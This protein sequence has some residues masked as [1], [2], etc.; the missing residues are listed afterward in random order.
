MNAPPLSRKRK[1]DVER[2]AEI[3]RERRARTRARILAVTFDIFGRENGLYCR[4]EEVCAAAGITRQTF[5]NHFTGMEDLREALTWEVS[6][7]FLVAVTASIDAMP[8]AARRTAAAVRYYLE[9]GRVDPRWAW[10]IVNLSANGVV[11][12]AE[13]FA[14]AR[15]TIAEGIEA[16]LFTVSDDRIGRDIVM[17]ATLSALFT[18]LREATPD[19]YPRQVAGAVLAALGCDASRCAAVAALALPHL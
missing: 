11:F 3:G 4:V 13:T 12:G 15:R 18:Q 2:R 19:D 1:V 8:D 6:H 16:G 17:G 14:Q 7:D 10:S 9:R 5:Y